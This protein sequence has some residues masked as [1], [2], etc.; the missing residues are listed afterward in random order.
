L[1]YKEEFHSLPSVS[2]RPRQINCPQKAMLLDRGGFRKACRLRGAGAGA[3]TSADGPTSSYESFAHEL[4]ELEKGIR[5]NA[6]GAS[7]EDASRFA[8][9]LRQLTDAAEAFA[10]AREAAPAPAPVA[11]SV[12][13]QGDVDSSPAADVPAAATDEAP[14]PAQ[15]PVPVIPV[16]PA[17]AALAGAADALPVTTA[18]PTPVA[19][20]AVPTPA[21]IPAPKTESKPTDEATS[22][23]SPDDYANRSNLA[24]TI[25]SGVNAYARRLPPLTPE[26]FESVIRSGVDDGSITF[27]EGADLESEVFPKYGAAFDTWAACTKL[28]YDNLGWGDT[29]IGQLADAFD[30]AFKRSGTALPLLSLDLRDNQMV[31]Q[32]TVRRLQQLVVDGALANVTKI[33]WR[34]CNVQK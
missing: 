25:E 2:V 1:Q 24:S 3:S 22:G 32:A 7:P 30:S 5:D 21:F 12:P 23:E 9:R 27:T 29:E 20:V 18:I 8:L 33:N 15:A 4:A 16:T 31:S 10:A 17:D 26:A 13:P 14:A 28:A 34:G 11:A 19:A 6:S